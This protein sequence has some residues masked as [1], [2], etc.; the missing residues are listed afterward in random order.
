V[1]FT[2]EE[3]AL[4]YVRDHEVD[5]AILDIK[6]KKMSGVD[7]L[8]SLRKIRP[9]AKAI[10][11]TGYPTVQTAEESI[12]RGAYDYLTKPLDI[13]QL[14]EKVRQVLSPPEKREPEKNDLAEDVSP[15]E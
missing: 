14:E 9:Q 15:S 10:M 12:T 6:L 11:L 8:A 7:V 5:L 2:E 13:D 3:S 4:E 1:A